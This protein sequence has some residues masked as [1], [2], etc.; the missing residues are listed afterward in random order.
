MS[1]RQVQRKIKALLGISP[2]EALKQFRLKKARKQLE[3]GDQI[4]VVAQTCGFSSQSYFGR[5][6]KEE[7][8]MTPKAFQQSFQ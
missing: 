2:L 4:G 6:F 5:C 7:F 1:D 8:N 3:K